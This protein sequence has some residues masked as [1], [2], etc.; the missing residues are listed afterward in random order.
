MLII[1]KPSSEVL[2]EGRILGMHLRVKMSSRYFDLIIFMVSQ[3]VTPFEY[4][5]ITNP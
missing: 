4:E 1:F 5:Q 3:F 2:K